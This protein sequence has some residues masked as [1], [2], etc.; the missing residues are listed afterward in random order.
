M[1]WN[2][3]MGEWLKR[4]LLLSAIVGGIG[5]IVA[6]LG[7]TQLIWSLFR[8][9]PLLPYIST[10]APQWVKIILA[11][12]FV[13]IFIFCVFVVV[14][15]YRQAKK[16]SKEKLL[17]RSEPAER[18]Y[19]LN[20]LVKGIPTLITDIDKRRAELIQIKLDKRMASGDTQFVFNILN[21]AWRTFLGIEPPTL[22]T[23]IGDEDIGTIVRAMLEWAANCKDGF[24]EL[25]K[26]TEKLGDL[27]TGLVLAR[28]V[29]KHLGID[30]EL[31]KESMNGKL[32]SARELLPSSVAVETTKAIDN[33]L[34]YSRA[35]RATD[36][37][38]IPLAKIMEEN[39][40]LK[41]IP[42][43]KQVINI[44]QRFKEKYLEQMNINL[45]KVNEAL[46]L[47]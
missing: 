21:D 45:A 7:A 26:R 20:E 8:S 34:D 15:V 44:F 10:T 17:R 25:K 5:M 1:E 27:E 41:S 28:A 32:E 4:H 18:N 23:G 16:A 39:D 19:E 42:Q 38:L 6:V 37:V 31:A 43:M 2:R 13:A 35:Y 46:K 40:I 14:R 3:K 30:D 47:L 9:E 22:P 12:V 29:N 36:I 11:I 33:Y 24:E